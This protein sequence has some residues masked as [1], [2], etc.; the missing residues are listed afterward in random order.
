MIFAA[1]GALSL[2]RQDVPAD[3]AAALYVLCSLGLSVGLG[4][5]A[6]RGH[7]RLA[8][9]RRQLD[10]QGQRPDHHAVG[11]A[12]GAPSSRWGPSPTSPAG[13]PRTGAG[14]V[15]L[16]LGISFAVQNLIV[17]QRT[18]A[19]GRDTVAVA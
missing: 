19:R 8:G 11:R 17:A 12:R 15:F 6:R 9:R 3:A 1:I 18:L 16:F 4:H 13:S 10:E 5:L 14:E 7:P 2:T